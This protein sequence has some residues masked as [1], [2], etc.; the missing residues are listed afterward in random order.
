MT[1]ISDIERVNHL[2]WRLKRLENFI[3]KSD[4]F[5]KKRITEAIHDL[6]E[7][8]LRQA[9]NNNNAKSVLSKANEI[10][11][12][13][14]SEFQ[15]H[16]MADRATKLEL[17]L[18]DEDR[19]REVTK[20][21]SEIDSLARVLDGEQFQEIPKLMSTLSKL[22]VTH[23]ENKNHHSEFTQDLSNFLQN[24]AAFTLMM[25]E[26]L[27]QYK[28]ILS[29]NQKASAEIQD[30]PIMNS[31][32]KT[33]SSINESSS[34]LNALHR[35][36]LQPSS[37]SQA[38]PMVV[39]PIVEND[40]ALTVADFSV[41]NNTSTTVPMS[42][43]SERHDYSPIQPYWF[44][45]KK[46]QD[47]VTWIPFSLIDVQH[48]DEAYAQNRE[49]IATNGNRYD[50]NLVERIRTPVY[51]TD[52]PNAIR[53]S[54]WF[55]LP[56]QESRFIPFDE[57][58][59]ETLE[60]LYEETCRKQSWHTKHE[61]NSGKEILIFHSPLL[62]TIQAIEGEITP[63]ANFTYETRTVKRGLPEMFFDEIKFGDKDPVQHVCFVVHGIGEAC[64][65][66]FRPLIECVE[67]FRETSRTILQSHFKT[68]VENGEI[69]RVEFLPVYWHGDL[70]MDATG[71]DGHLLSLTL[72][73]VAKLRT[74][75]NTTLS[76][77]LFYTSPVY[78]QKIISRCIS[79]MNRLYEIFLQRNPSFHGQVSVIGHSLGT[80]ILYDILVNQTPA[81]QEEAILNEAENTNAT[82]NVCV[83]GTGQ[84]SI[85]YEKL[86]FPV[87]YFFALGNFELAKHSFIIQF[88]FSGSPIAMFLTVRGVTSLASDYALPTCKGL[89]NIFHPYD[90]VAYR[91]EPLIDPKWI[92]SPVLLPH[93]KGRKRLHLELIDGLS[94]ATD[95]KQKMLDSFKNTMI[96]ITDFVQSYR[97]PAS[98]TASP[99]TALD[100]TATTTATTRTT[101]TT[102]ETELEL[103]HANDDEETHI[104]EWDNRP[105]GKLN[106]GRR[107]DYVLQH[108]PIEALNDYI[109]A[110][111]S[112]VSYWDSEDTM[113]LII[114]EILKLDGFDPEPQYET[115]EQMIKSNV[116][117]YFVN[118][119][120]TKV[121]E[122]RPYLA[123]SE[124]ISR[125][126]TDPIN[127]VQ[128]LS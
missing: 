88:Y 39:I 57:K 43:E 81:T 124:Q 51:W 5:D 13:T 35:L 21:L 33:K 6:N 111:T 73:S 1:T 50:V 76:D 114:K 64:D 91:L 128:R 126:I 95:L 48:L 103:E 40:V 60:N 46:V 74:F 92:V 97:S 18:A 10:N 71:V 84:I 27:Q 100:P 83:S 47:R 68:Y 120:T 63:W 28:Q 61:M 11:H 24:Y 14:S 117:N 69:H 30:N 94:K 79:E 36:P 19:I 37:S 101:T 67:D 53:R 82:K 22:L 87:A 62:M 127:I 98:A 77:I 89:L 125:L 118:N 49:V 106:Q 107:I 31:N 66:K 32:E 90:P 45:S 7:Q 17:I 8:V 41:T 25:D 75:I 55:Y 26:N 34:S 105:I 99:A 38:N 78:C 104:D 12:L 109:F 15:R 70:H 123:K 54:K 4:K 121:N 86:T 3:G 9:N 56:E 108:R 59:N 65:T 72:P 2:E 113:L 119:Q 110:F 85:Q 80:V 44:Y 23:N 115:I 116:L 58:M 20:S 122:L 93:H 29:K 102:T 96:S 52:E 16:L 112:H 42:S